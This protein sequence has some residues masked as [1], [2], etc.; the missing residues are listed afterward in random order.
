MSTKDSKPINILTFSE[1][2]KK[3]SIYVLYWLHDGYRFSQGN[4]MAFWVRPTTDENGKTN[5]FIKYYRV[6]FKFIHG[7]DKANIKYMPKY[8]KLSSHR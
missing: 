1:G 7:T 3:S 4:A 8:R 6:L 2:N 5:L